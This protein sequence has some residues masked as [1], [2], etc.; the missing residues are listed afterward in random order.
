M[1]PLPAALDADALLTGWRI[2]RAT[3]AGTWD[4]G[5]G[6][7]RFGGRWNPRGLKVVYACLDPATCLVEAAVHRG[8]KV[9]DTE[10]HVLTSF[11][12]LDPGTVRVVMP[13]EIPNPAWLQ[14]TLPSAGQQRWGAAMLAE[15]RFIVLPST[16]SRQS[17]NL[18]FDPNSSRGLYRIQEQSRLVVDTRL[19]PVE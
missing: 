15:H 19:N 18:L 2:D 12:L 17:W 5:A 6:A 11:V 8:F 14:S 9:L 7:E 1:V 3:Y 13:E 16:V 4:S 10:P